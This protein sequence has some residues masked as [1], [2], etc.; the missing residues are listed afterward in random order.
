MLAAPLRHSHTETGFLK[1][2][3]CR[4]VIICRLI[5]RQAYELAARDDVSVQH[6]A[7]EWNFRSKR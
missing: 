4:L 5:K 3:F 7:I 6:D 2:V 1:I